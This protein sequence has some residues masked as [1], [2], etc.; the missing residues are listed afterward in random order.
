MQ[1][2]CAIEDHYTDNISHIC[3]NLNVFATS[4][5]FRNDQ[6]GICYNS[7]SSI[8]TTARYVYKRVHC[9]QIPGVSVQC[10]NTV[11]YHCILLA[12]LA[13]AANRN[14][15]CHPANCT[16]AT[17]WWE[18]E[19]CIYALNFFILPKY[20]RCVVQQG[21]RNSTKDGRERGSNSFCLFILM[22]HKKEGPS[23]SFIHGSNPKCCISPTSM[24]VLFPSS[25]GQSIKRIVKSISGSF[26]AAFMY[27]TKQGAFAICA[28]IKNINA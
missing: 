18:R 7:T 17:N 14:L 19:V 13:Y 16:L 20:I 9:T 12:S 1:I 4:L 3:L 11:F 24:V 6:V 27:V 22:I 23:L 26:I 10:H 21:C 28:S 15:I 2:Q 25:F 5:A 8:W